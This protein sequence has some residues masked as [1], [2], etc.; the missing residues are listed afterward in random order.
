[1]VFFVMQEKSEK[2][3]ILSDVIIKIS[4]TFAAFLLLNINKYENTQYDII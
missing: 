3:C 2:K 4:I 1:M